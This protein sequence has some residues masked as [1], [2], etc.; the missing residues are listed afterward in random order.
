MSLTGGIEVFPNNT[1]TFYARYAY[2][3][4]DMYIADDDLD[5]NI[6]L[7]QSGIHVGL[8]FRLLGGPVVA[9][10]VAAAA[11]VAPSQDSDGDGFIDIYDECPN[12]YGIAK[13]TGCPAPD[14]DGDGVNDDDD[15]CPELPGSAE[16]RGC[17]EMVYYFSNAE[18]TL[19]NDDKANLNSAADFLNRYPNL[20]AI[21]EGHT[22]TDGEADFNQR[23]SEQRAQSSVDYLVS[24][25]ISRSR[26][27]AKG[28][29][30]QFPIGDNNTPE[31]K[32]KSRRVVVR[33]Q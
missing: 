22:S 28:F 21:V 12:V 1:V 6:E 18:S 19:T 16:N 32:A 15:R 20:I 7:N 17:L 33:I 24:K 14:T 9:A 4:N 25:G 27:S 13:Y 5:N 30:E 23:L 11:A 10:S 2:G 8:K 31:G 3:F 26:I 29:G